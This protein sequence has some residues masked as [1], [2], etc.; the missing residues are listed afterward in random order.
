MLIDIITAIQSRYETNPTEV[1]GHYMSIT[2][3]IMSST[4]A[5]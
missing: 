4:R 2:S 5:D 1:V 3:A